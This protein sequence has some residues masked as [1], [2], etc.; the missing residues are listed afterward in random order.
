MSCPHVTG[1]F[2]MGFAAWRFSPCSDMYHLSTKKNEVLRLVAR[3]TADKLGRFA[4]RDPTNALGY[5]IANVNAFTT[6]LLNPDIHIQT[7]A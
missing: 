7:V 1:L 6:K 4:D 2:A 5:G 3:Q